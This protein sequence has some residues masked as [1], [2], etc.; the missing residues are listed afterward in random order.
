MS[1]KN[2]LVIVP[3]MRES[4]R[5]LYM[6]YVRDL[7]ESH[8]E[9]YKTLCTTIEN[10]EKET[11]QVE[12]SI[13][14]LSTQKEN[15]TE[16]KEN[17]IVT[18]SKDYTLVFSAILAGPD[19]NPGWKN[20]W[21]HFLLGEEGEQYELA[22]ISEIMQAYAKAYD[23]K[24]RDTTQK[25]IKVLRE[26]IMTSSTILFNKHSVRMYHRGIEGAVMS[27]RSKYARFAPSKLEY[28][29]SDMNAIAFV[30]S[31]YIIP[32]GVLFSS[33]KITLKSLDNSSG[34]IIRTNISTDSPYPLSIVPNESRPNG[35]SDLLLTNKVETT[36][37]S[38]GTCR[39][40]IYE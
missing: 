10:I 26:G 15:H 24:D 20:Y 34:L 3:G 9:Q 31:E 32:K 12:K 35:K 18:L 2:P 38:I 1:K 6:R 30:S 39:N 37:R 5:S 22:T 17:Q 28:N 19:T 21:S 27:L 40:I 8:P 25:I 13:E 29:A 33:R 16:E 14:D 11:L 7:K 36:K 23:R 4:A